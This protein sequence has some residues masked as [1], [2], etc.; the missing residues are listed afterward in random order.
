MNCH[1][2]NVLT[3]TASHVVICAT[4]AQHDLLDSIVALPNVFSQYFLYKLQYYTDNTN[5]G[6]SEFVTSTY[7]TNSSLSLVTPMS[8]YPVGRYFDT[9]GRCMQQHSRQNIRTRSNNL[10]R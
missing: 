9:C 4:F 8:K 6:V 5:S 10:F 3:C 7:F 2:P 1:D